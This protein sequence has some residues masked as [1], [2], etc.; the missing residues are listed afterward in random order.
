MNMQMKQRIDETLEQLNEQH[1]A[2]VMDFAEFL[3]V[4]EQ[5]GNSARTSID[6]ALALLREIVKSPPKG[7]LGPPY[8]DLTGFKFD[9]EE[10]NAR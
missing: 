8:L 9:R 7:R 10:A 5:S 3:K 6:E 2:E 1:I 4:R